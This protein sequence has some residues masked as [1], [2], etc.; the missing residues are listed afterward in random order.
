MYLF[1]LKMLKGNSELFRL[2]FLFIQQTLSAYVYKDQEY[3]MNT[4]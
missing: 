2:N 1:K 3:S 4:T